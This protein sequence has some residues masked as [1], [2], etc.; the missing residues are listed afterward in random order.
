MSH[1]LKKTFI[2]KNLG[3]LITSRFISILGDTIFYPAIFWIAASN[4]S[5]GIN[6]VGVISFIIVLPPLLSFLSGAIIDHLSKKFVLI[7][8]DSVRTALCFIL[9]LSPLN[10]LLIILVIFIFFIELCGQFFSVASAALIPQIVNKDE[11][12]AANSHLQFT[13]T[14]VSLIGYALGGVLMVGFGIYVVILINCLSFLISALLLVFVKIPNTNRKSVKNNQPSEKNK[15]NII[16]ELAE[17]MKQLTGNRG[18]SVITVTSFIINTAFASIEVL[19]TVWAHNTGKIG[20][21]G[22]GFLLT[23]IMVGSLLGALVT[24][25]P[26]FNSKAKEYIIAG[27]VCLE[28]IFLGLFPFTFSLI[29]SMSS[30]FL[31]GLFQ[32]LGN[33][34]F[35][36]YL[37]EQVNDK[38]LGKV[39]G[40]INTLMRGGQPMGIAIITF[41]LGLIRV[42]WLVL[43]VGMITLLCGVSIVA[44]FRFKRIP[45]YIGRESSASK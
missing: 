19:I 41:L 23:S 3:L 37:M 17:G 2:N 36:T 45:Y 25:I 1:L 11:Y 43:I 44:F 33:V 27:A 34:Y 26:Y 6:W 20:A 35:S 40:L 32:M 9:L 14:V 8:S 4:S 28:G 29:G 42:S 10:N 24:R 15:V 12:V 30:L 39:L 7:V 18:L 5:K 22:Y 31:M 13:S 16:K 38:N 21:A